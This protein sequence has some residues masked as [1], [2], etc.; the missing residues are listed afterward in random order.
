[1]PLTSIDFT[2]RHILRVMLYWI[3]TSA[4][5]CADGQTNTAVILRVLAAS[6]DE[7]RTMGYGRSRPFETPRK[8]AAP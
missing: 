1:M 6:C 5:S 7:P 3:H 2:F 4:T 8:R